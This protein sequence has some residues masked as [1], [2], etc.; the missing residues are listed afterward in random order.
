MHERRIWLFI[1]PHYRT[2]NKELLMNEKQWTELADS[3]LA[4]SATTTRFS[5]GH[6][7]CATKA[8]LRRA[9]GFAA[10]KHSG[11][12]RKGEGHTPYIHHPIEVAAT[13]A[14]IGEVEDL[15]LLQ[16]ALL[17]DTVEDTDTTPDEIE[18]HFGSRV[19]S[20]V[21]EVT[22]DKSL[23]KSERKAAQIAH[24]PHLSK[25]AQSLKLADK[26]SNVHDVAFCTPVD[27]SRQRQLEYF[28]WAEQVVAG[29]R[30]CNATLESLFDEQLARSRLA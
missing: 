6:T 12:F 21:R 15:E 27:W 7:F 29:L 10:W 19:C 4:T 25:E 30:G 14:E 5:K 22:D 9:V 11:Q 8:K 28:A 26:I 17:H 18:T 2:E 24:A 1:A 3:V 23:E 20:I 16:A 13:L